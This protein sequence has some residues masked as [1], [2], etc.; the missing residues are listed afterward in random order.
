MKKETGLPKIN[1]LLMTHWVL[2]PNSFDPKSCTPSAQ[3]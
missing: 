3:T 2:E 1:Q